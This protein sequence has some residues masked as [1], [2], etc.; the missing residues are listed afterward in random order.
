MCVRPDYFIFCDPLHLLHNQ[1]LRS[2]LYWLWAQ[3]YPSS[4]CA[5]PSGLFGF[6]HAM[7]WSWIQ[8]VFFS[9]LDPRRRNRLLHP[10][11]LGKVGWRWMDYCTEA[12]IFPNGLLFQSSF[13]SHLIITQ[14]CRQPRADWSMAS[15]YSEIMFSQT[16]FGTS[17]AYSVIT[18]CVF[19]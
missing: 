9:G 1:V 7:D 11:N 2:I 3:M 19:N 16:Q 8:W 4:T 10:S 6:S 13:P 18:V 5:L 14:Y 15:E 12:V 17:V